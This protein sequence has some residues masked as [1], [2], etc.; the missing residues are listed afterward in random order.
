MKYRISE[1]G[2]ASEIIDADDLK[3]AVAAAKEWAS[4]GSY[5]ERVMVSVYVQSVDE[6]GDDTDEYGSAEVEAGPEPEAPECAEGEE[7]EWESPHELVGGIKENPGVWSLGGTTMTFHYVCGHC[8]AHKHET[9][10]G[11]QR[12]PGQCDQVTYEE[13]DDDTK[14]W[15]KQR[16]EDDGWIPQ[17]LA[18]YLE[19]SPSV[20]MTEDEAKEYVTDHTDEE[21]LDDDDL[22]HAFAAIS[23][24][25]ADDQDRAEGLWS[26]IN[27]AVS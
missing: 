25:R 27:A 2:G 15:L 10:Y 17:W 5:D 26:Q 14:E 19:C 8:G 16:Q 9:C 1:D 18:D 20:R 24:R 4:E 7:H 6:D 22:E 11:S 12:N 23:G 21:E 3:S 13:A